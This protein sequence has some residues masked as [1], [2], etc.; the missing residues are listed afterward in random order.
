VPTAMTDG[1][2]A[3]CAW[4]GVSRNTKDKTYDPCGQFRA[5]MVWSAGSFTLGKNKYL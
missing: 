1:E 4:K 2:M 5:L 3:G